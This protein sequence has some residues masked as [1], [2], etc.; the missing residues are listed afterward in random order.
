M[1]RLSEYTKSK[2]YSFEITEGNMCGRIKRVISIIKRL[3]PGV[4]L[5]VGCSDGAWATYWMNT[6]WQAFGV[7]MNPRNVEI[8]QKRGVQAA[9]VDL[10]NDKLPFDS[11]FF[12]L[13]FAGEIIEHLIDTDGFLRELHRCLRP[14]GHLLLTTPNLAS[15]EN[16]IRI[17]LG[18]YPMWVNYGLHG[19][20][21]IRAYTPRVLKYQLRQH[22][23]GIIKH[24]GNWVPFIPQKIVDDLELP[25]LSLT[26][27]LF[28]NLAMDIIV[29]A[30]K[31]V[32]S[33]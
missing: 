32:S 4:L 25:W 6:G 33:I 30:R 16:R 23:F 24:T 29:L 14:Q 28:P 17:L 22:G 3:L 31:N 13:I 19:S 1:K 11:N 5:D 20:G 8:A 2:D 9:V 15:F 27:I 10:N 18:R 7:D 26:G 21:H 12:D